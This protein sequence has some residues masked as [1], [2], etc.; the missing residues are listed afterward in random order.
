MKMFSF[1]REGTFDKGNRDDDTTSVLCVGE[2]IHFKIHD[3]MYEDRSK[4]E[5]MFPKDVSFIPEFSL[6]EIVVNPGDMKVIEC[7]FS[8]APSDIQLKKLDRLQARAGA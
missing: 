6:I 5:G 1:L 2:T 7:F 4:G 8:V 3:F